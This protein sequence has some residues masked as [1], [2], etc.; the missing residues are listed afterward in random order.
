M[1]DEQREYDRNTVRNLPRFLAQAG[2]Q[3]VRLETRVAVLR[4][5]EAAALGRY[6]PAG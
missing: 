2:L 4:D 6:Y 1:P 3:V 5:D